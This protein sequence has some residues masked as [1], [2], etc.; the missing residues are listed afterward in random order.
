M[1]RVPAPLLEVMARH[2]EAAYPEEGCGLLVGRNEGGTLLV[3]RLIPAWNVACRRRTT[4]E[5]DP[6]VCFTTLRDVRQSDESL[7]GHYHSHPDR[8]PLPSQRDREMTFDPQMIWLI[9]EVR[10][11]RLVSTQAYRVAADANDLLPFP[12]AIIV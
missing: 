5:I 8:P 11:H 2:L 3:T 1:I 9:S 7:I 12:L 6:Q 10:D 4:F